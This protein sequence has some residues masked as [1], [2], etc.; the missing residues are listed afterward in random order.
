[1]KNNGN[2]DQGLRQFGMVFSSKQKHFHHNFSGKHY[3][4]LE[5]SSLASRH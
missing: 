4:L 2:V 1:M 5:T 3:Q